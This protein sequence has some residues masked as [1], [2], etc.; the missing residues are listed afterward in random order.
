MPFHQS[1]LENSTSSLTTQLKWHLPLK[2][3]PGDMHLSAFP[4]YSANT[5]ALNI[6]MNFALSL[7]A[8]GK[9]HVFSILAF[10]LAHSRLSE[11][12]W[13]LKMSV[14]ICSAPVMG[15]HR[16]SSLH[17]PIEARTLQIR[18]PRLREA[19]PLPKISELPSDASRIKTKRKTK[20][21]FSKYF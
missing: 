4:Q 15:Q 16:L 13:R 7:S 6:G 11:S 21:I 1:F 19:S 18:K 20:W 12:I 3:S 17:Q 2:P 5:L 9:S 10:L 14:T 8:H